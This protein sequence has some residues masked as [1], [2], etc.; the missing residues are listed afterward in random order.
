MMQAGLFDIPTKYVI[1]TSSIIDL[2]RLYPPER[3]VFY[4]LWE[5]ST[6]QLRKTDHLFKI[7]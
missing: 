1:D 3:K 5:K 6:K 4:P 2:F 7:C